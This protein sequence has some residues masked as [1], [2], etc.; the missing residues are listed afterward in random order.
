MTPLPRADLSRR[1]RYALWAMRIGAI[2]LTA[3]VVYTFVSQ[4]S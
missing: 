1:A 4:L 2:V 3:M